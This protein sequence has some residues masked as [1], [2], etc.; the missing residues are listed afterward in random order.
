MQVAPLFIN[1]EGIDGAGKSTVAS[2]LHRRGLLDGRSV[3]ILE[4][5]SLEGLTPYKHYHMAAIKGVLWDYSDDDP[6]ESLGDHHWY[7]LICA[8]YYAISEI[9]SNCGAEIVISD[10]YYYKYLARFSLK[11]GFDIDYLRSAYL[12]IRKP[13]INALLDIDP[14]EA[15]RR[16]TVMKRSESGALN[17]FVA[18]DVRTS[19]VEYQAR[20][21]AVLERELLLSAR[22]L[23][24]NALEPVD[25]IVERIWQEATA[26]LVCRDADAR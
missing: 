10:G 17:G 23:K 13:D 24:C 21:G 9:I 3:K 12:P 15:F 2:E 11:D 14:S 7:H 6:I 4:K 26:A 16:K 18:K 19:F 1:I 25:I 22:I 8:W 20:V 5:R